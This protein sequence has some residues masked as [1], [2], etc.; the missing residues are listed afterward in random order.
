MRKRRSTEEREQEVAGWRESGTSAREYARARGY[1][2]QSLERWAKAHGESARF[3]RL[4]VAR[5]SPRELAVQ[6]GAA[7]I[8]VACGFDAELL[9]AVVSALSAGSESAT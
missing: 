8:V 6:V 9:R 5:P 4:E 2:V 7:R 3:V 1:S